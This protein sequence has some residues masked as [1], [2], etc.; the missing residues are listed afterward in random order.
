MLVTRTFDLKPKLDREM[1]RLGARA[2]GVALRGA[3]TNMALFAALVSACCGLV[4]VISTSALAQTGAGEHGAAHAASNQPGSAPLLFMTDF[5]VAD[6]AVAIC[7]GVMLEMAPDL[8]IIDLTHDV[9]PF[10][11]RE[12]AYYL[13]QTAPHYPG[14]TVFVAV[15]DPGV[16]TERAAIALQ[17]DR[18]QFFVGPDNG[19]FSLVAIEQGV[20]AVHAVTNPAFMRS[21]P[22]PTF[23]GRDVFS[24]CGA[25]L[26]S[27][28]RI[29]DVGAKLD[30]IVTL[31][32]QT[33][34]H[35]RGRIRA[36]IALLDKSF[37][38]VWT[39]VPKEMV[40]ELIKANGDASTRL[41]VTIGDWKL[42]IPLVR[43]FGDVREGE[44]LAYFNSRDRL[45]FA[46]NMGSF[47]ERY[48]V[49][50][51]EIVEVE[52]IP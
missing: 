34:V 48:G 16:G 46:I 38:N 27:G 51:G 3:G 2:T 30:G 4:A 7:K 21:D 35:E 29:E 36:E 31:E 10:D 13:A 28:G 37:G 33:P 39:N 8:R 44:P 43:T 50:P 32:I 25:K 22:S 19:I 11:V 6:D 9:T 45:S 47:A 49:E 15:V 1:R 41:S 24:P 40:D 12:G 23:H 17:T 26:A 14:G 20:R 42:T 52:A 18:G 5:G